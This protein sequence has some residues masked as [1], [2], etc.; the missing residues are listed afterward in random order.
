MN[1]RE[2]RPLSSS[3]SFLPFH[4]NVSLVAPSCLLDSVHETK[5][6]VVIVDLISFIWWL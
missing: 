5:V 4:F 1:I 2:T 3:Q 6:V